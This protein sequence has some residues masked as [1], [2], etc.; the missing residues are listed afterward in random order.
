ML[1]RFWPLCLLLA[2]LVGC[3]ITSQGTRIERQ[4]DSSTSR[5]LQL[6]SGSPATPGKLA[7]DAALLDLDGNP[8]QLKQVLDR[9]DKKLGK[10]PT[11]LLFSSTSCPYSAKEHIEVEAAMKTFTKSAKV[12]T[13][14]VNETPESVREYLDKNRVP[15]T[16]LFDSK[17]EA[18]H[19][20]KIELVPTLLMVNSKGYVN[21]FGHYTLSS[22]VVS[23]MFKLYREDEG[24]GSSGHARRV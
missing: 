20:Y 21:H 4:E 17:G 19:A 14:L 5:L 3:A 15:G 23:L 1:H 9:P 22:D 10:L 6:L 13:I 18:V 11:I 12:V 24:F 8:I 7:P 2:M 16:V